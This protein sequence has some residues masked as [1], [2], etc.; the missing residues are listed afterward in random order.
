MGEDFGAA[1]AD[2]G[3]DPVG[4]QAEAGLVIGPLQKSGDS[5][6]GIEADEAVG[7]GALMEEEGGQ[8]GALAVKAEHGGKI[9][10]GQ[11]VA[12]LDEEGVAETEEGFHVFDAAGG[13]EE[14]VFTNI[15]QLYF[16]G[17]AAAEMS[18]DGAG[19][20][21][22]VDGHLVKMMGAQVGE[23][24]FED[25]ASVE[26]EHGLGNLT[27]E[28]AQPCSVARAQNHGSHGLFK[29]HSAAAGRL[30]QVQSGLRSGSIGSAV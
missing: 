30:G 3:I 26:G 21:V 27:G 8:G 9:L 23:D 22:K 11:D 18:G 4:W 6:L 16:Q 19:Q 24:V 29:I 7:T 1:E 13:A 17:G 14:A 10:V 25:G 20:K 12:I 28:I 2:A 5:S 15:S